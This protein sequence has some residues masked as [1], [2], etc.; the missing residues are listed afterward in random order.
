VIDS[1][2]PQPLKLVGANF[3]NT[4]TT[5][6]DYET[7]SPRAGG[8]V[9]PRVMHLRES[10][11]EFAAGGFDRQLITAN[12]A[13]L[14]CGHAH[15]L[16]TFDDFHGVSLSRCGRWSRF[17][18]DRAASLV[19]SNNDFSVSNST[20]PS[21]K[22]TLAWPWWRRWAAAGSADLEMIVLLCR[23]SQASPEKT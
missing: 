16:G 9:P 21:L 4:R 20:C 13:G 23:H 11:G 7:S 1:Q 14:N 12:F 22:T 3:K 10:G 8:A 17:Q 18:R 15:E 2:S 6:C 5:V 19:S